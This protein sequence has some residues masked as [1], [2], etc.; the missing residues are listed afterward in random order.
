MK[1]LI[2][3][4]ISLMLIICCSTPFQPV[5]PIKVIQQQ[6]IVDNIHHVVYNVNPYSKHS[7]IPCQTGRCLCDKRLIELEDC[8]EIENYC[9]PYY[10]GYLK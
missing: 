4:S 8:Y 7:T 3:L 2:V 1:T 6:T 10:Y 5:K 9:S